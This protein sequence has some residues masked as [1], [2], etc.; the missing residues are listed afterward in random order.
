MDGYQIFQ[1]ILDNL[2]VPILLAIGGGLAVIA[3]K[4]TDK[5]GNSITVKNE[6]ESIEKRMKTRQ[7][8]LNTLRPTVEA[9]VASNMQLA[10]T[11]RQTNGKLKEEDVELLNNSAKELVLNTLPDSLTEEDG[12]LLDIIGGRDQLEAAIKIMIEQYVYEYKLKASQANYNYN[13]NSPNNPN[14]PVET[15]TQSRGIPYPTASV[16][17]SYSGMNQ[18]VQRPTV[19]Q[20]PVIQPAP[21]NETPVG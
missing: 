4:W 6:I 14:T 16:I 3:T 5:I 7:D 15:T 21:T 17:A 13:T 9:A 12:V 8:I 20:Q 19:V 18:N 2:A 10:S 1:V 11:L